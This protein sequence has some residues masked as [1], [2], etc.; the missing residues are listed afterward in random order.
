MRLLVMVSRVGASV[1]TAGLITPPL[2]RKEKKMVKTNHLGT[3]TAVAGALVAVGLVVLIMV[4]V[5]AHPAE[6]TFPGKPGKI[7]YEGYDGQDWEIYSINPN[8]GG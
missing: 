4:V 7:A 6:A 5:E 2:L 1:D 3:L 8:G